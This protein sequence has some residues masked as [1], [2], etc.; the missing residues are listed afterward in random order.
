[1][2]SNDADRLPQRRIML[3]ATRDRERHVNL[4]SELIE[5]GGG[6]DDACARRFLEA[7]VRRAAPGNRQNVTKLVA[8]V[9]AWRRARRTVRHFFPLTER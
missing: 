4:L 3:A 5:N 7:L 6:D 2:R 1:M 9:D 8:Q